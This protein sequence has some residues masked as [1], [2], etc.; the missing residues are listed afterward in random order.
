MSQKPIIYGAVGIVLGFLGGVAAG[1]AINGS[2]ITDAVGR[3]MGPAQEAASQA[4]SSQ[5]AALDGLSERIAALE[6]AMSED[7]GGEDIT[8]AL[9]ERLDAMKSEMQTRLEDLSARTRTQAEA[10]QGALSELSGG[11]QEAAQMAAAAVA[12]RAAGS[13][14]GA[15]AE[16]MTVTDPL[17]VG[18]T[19]QFADGQV[20]AFVSRVDPAGGS[21][22]LMVNG[23]ATALGS[24]G[25]TRV[26]LGDSSCTVAV[27]GL[28]DGKATL[29]SD[30]GA[31]ASGGS[32]EGGESEAAAAPAEAPEDGHRAGEV[33]SLADGKLR[34]FVSGLADDGSAARIAVNGVQT[35]LVNAGES[36]EV[37]TGEGACTVTVTGV[38]NGMVGLEASCG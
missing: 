18:E 34:V 11:M 8:A 22:R 7:D 3:A 24:G 12:A 37:E 16:G 31:A 13:G 2:K 28:D 17:G 25:T 19:A 4:A 21:V 27:M 33:A 32:E 36:V 1:S 14:E 5:Q 26:A 30:C 6:A 20:R 35:Q 10:V 15:S 38:G 23:E 29:G 9:G